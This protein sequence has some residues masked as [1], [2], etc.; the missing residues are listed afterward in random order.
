MAP[1]GL[2]LSL[3]RPELAPDLPNHVGQTSEVGLGC[4]Q[5]PLCLLLAAAILQDSGGL[6]DNRPPVLG[7]G[8]QDALNLALGDDHMLLA[9][10][11]GVAQ[12]ALGCQAVGRARR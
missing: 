2:G 12:A 5:P 8:A 4:G 7:P 3:Q 10:Y 11:A 9:T 1:S 6:F